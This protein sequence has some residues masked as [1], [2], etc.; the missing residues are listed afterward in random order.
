MSFAGRRLS[1]LDDPRLAEVAASAFP[2]WL[3]S[4]DAT[5]VLWAN[6][7]GAAIFGAP[8]TAALPA[9][10]FDAGQPAAAQ[11]LRLAA[12]L[13]PGAGPRPE[14]LRGF[15]AGVGRA[16]TCQCA[17]IA[18]ADGT[19]AILVAAS[20]RAGPDLPL[21]ERLRRLLA[22]AEEP[23]AAFAA[24]GA[25]MQVSGHAGERLSAAISIAQIGA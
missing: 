11:I 25:V 8:T 13:T 2:A 24:D 14:R 16:L 21:N 10:K 19:A 12:T 3:W 23:V 7:T 18:L 4:I 6:A 17:Q 22:G 5:H 15:G 1:W 20:E 9:R